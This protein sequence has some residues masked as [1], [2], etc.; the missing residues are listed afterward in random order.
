MRILYCN[1]YNFPFSGTEAYLFEL[2]ALVRSAGHE[3]ALFAMADARGDS[4]QYDRYFVSPV[5]FKDSSMGILKRAKL[6]G[7]AI[8]SWEARRRLRQ[9]IAEFRPEVAHVRNIYHHLSPSIFWELKAQ[10]VPVVYH[11][12]DFK[13]ICPNYNLVSHGQICERCVGGRFWHVVEQECYPGGRAASVVLAAEAYTHKWLRTYERCVDLFL[14]PSE[15]VKEKLVA[16]GWDA[17]K[18]QVLLHFQRLS[19]ERHDPPKEGAPILYFGRL[20]AE[21]GLRDLLHAMQRL[22]HIPLRIAGDGPQK[23]EL[24][25]LASE[26]GVRNVEFAG[27]LQGVELEELIRESGFTVFPSH[28]YETLGKSILESYAWARPVIASDLGSR[29]EVVKEHKTGMLFPVGNVDALAH[30]ISTL[31]EQPK[32]ATEMGSAAREFVRERHS[33]EKHYEAL[34]EMYERLVARR[35]VFPLAVK[36]R[37]LKVAFIGGRGVISKYSGIETYYEEVGRELAMMGHEITVYCR[38][39]FTP[40]Q[41]QYA[42]I[43]IVRLPT[44]RSKHL[45]TVIHT[46]LSTCHAM[47]RGYDIVHYHALGPALFSFL[48]RMTGKKT[49]VTVQG[50]DWQRRKWGFLA[51][52]ALRAG[53]WA[54]VRFPNA[55]MVVSKTLREHYKAHFQTD[56][57]YIPN[58]A[59]S[60]DTRN[61]SQLPL[62][63]LEPDQ[64]ILFLG[65]FSREKN[66]HLL[67]NAYKRLQTD[68]KLVLAGGSSHSDD[69]VS[70]LWRHKSENIRLL[71]W[72]AGEALDELLT[73]AMLFVLPSDLEGLSLALLDAMGAGVCVLASD[74]PE[75]REAVEGAGFTFRSG[76]VDDLSRIMQLLISSPG[77]R[78]SAAAKAKR[79]IFLHYQWPLIAAQIES[80]YWELVRG[81]GVKSRD[82]PQPIRPKAA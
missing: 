68:V 15:F 12:N 81:P 14:A 7:R 43:K 66:C 80:V 32:L 4:T 27:H 19:Q 46:L 73:N 51:S 35:T 64:Y 9:M 11:L 48:P 23:Q 13:A 44:I 65:R 5:N 53:E 56:T 79:R 58:G 70:E 38:S 28:A 26:L 42:G 2:M 37:R 52:H 17:G 1:K 33:P 71:D 40:Q 57:V 31:W 29:R 78:K 20:S 59:V 75:N 49:A 39:Y 69:Y 63:G 30:A 55:T 18:I 36:S 77:L 45:E 47:C 67:I 74:I 76:D 72:V 16:S 62:R 50:L 60:R 54:A 41:T 34:N 21:K 25:Q 82:V 61:G 8:Y 6:A 24:A 10:G 22:P 3:A